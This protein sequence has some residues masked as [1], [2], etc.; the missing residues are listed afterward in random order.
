MMKEDEENVHSFRAQRER[1]LGRPVNTVF[2]ALTISG[3]E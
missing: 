3:P 1:L 2:P